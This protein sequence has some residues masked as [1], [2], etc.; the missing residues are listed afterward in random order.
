MLNKFMEILKFKL[1]GLNC[2]ACVKLSKMKLKQLKGVKEV[3]IDLS[4]G[5]TEID[6]ER[7]I[8]FSEIEQAFKETDY[9]V[10]KS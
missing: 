6:T 7:S 1:G 8:S 9:S 2:E 3:R 5:L 10:I 4:T